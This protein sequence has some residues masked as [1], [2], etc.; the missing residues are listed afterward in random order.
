M[1][2]THDLHGLAKTSGSVRR[3]RL[4]DDKVRAL[5]RCHKYL[6]WAGCIPPDVEIEAMTCRKRHDILVK[7]TK[8]VAVSCAT[9]DRIAHTRR[10]AAPAADVTCTGPYQ[11]M[12]HRI[13]TMVDNTPWRH[14]KVKGKRGRNRTRPQSYSEGSCKYWNR[15][16]TSSANRAEAVEER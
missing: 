2:D 10:R 5:G 9:Y 12:P 15:M 7:T 14:H 8:S 1:A 16:C 4:G 11:G 6:L 13:S 3:A